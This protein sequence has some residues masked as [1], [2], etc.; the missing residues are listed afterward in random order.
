MKVGRVQK[1]SLL[2][3]FYLSRQ[4]VTRK[5]IA[6]GHALNRIKRDLF[7]ICSNCCFVLLVIRTSAWEFNIWGNISTKQEVGQILL[8]CLFIFFCQTF[9]FFYFFLQIE[10]KIL[11]LWI[12]ILWQPTQTKLFIS[13]TVWFVHNVQ[14]NLTVAKQEVRPFLCNAFMYWH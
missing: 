14:T 2:P 10:S 9:F 1:T 3:G 4:L 6:V 7:W 11:K 13:K 8:F 5:V 12:T